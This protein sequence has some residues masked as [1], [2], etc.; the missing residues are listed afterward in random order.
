ML[1]P[2]DPHRGAGMDAA[3]ATTDDDRGEGDF[4]VVLSGPKDATVVVVGQA[5][6][7]RAALVRCADVVTDTTAGFARYTDDPSDLLELANAALNSVSIGRATAICAAFDPRTRR[8]R[9]ASAG[10]GPRALPDGGRLVATP[11]GV[12]LGVS[13]EAQLDAG[14]HHLLPGTGLLLASGDLPDTMWQTGSHG[15]V[16]ASGRRTRM[17]VRALQG[18]TAQVV[19]D[20]IA[21]AILPGAHARRLRVV[22]LQCSADAARPSRGDAKRERQLAATAR[23]P[24]ALAAGPDTWRVAPVGE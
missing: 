13:E 20:G 2:S 11:R 14:E 24:A 19:A 9:W 15:T 5:I 21:D 3:E 23:R 17:A 18:G 1:S 6:A 16:A 12:A 8:L 4:A 7:P 22:V 10:H